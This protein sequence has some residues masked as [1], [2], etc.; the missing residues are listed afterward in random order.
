MRNIIFSA[1]FLL[2]GCSTGSMSNG[3]YYL[4]N[5]R[6]SKLENKY[7]KM[8]LLEERITLLEEKVKN[9]KTVS[10]NKIELVHQVSWLV[11]KNQSRK[12]LIFK[13]VGTEW[14]GPKGEYYKSFPTEKE[15]KL[16]YYE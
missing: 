11:M 3:T 13:M 5:N 1:L 10:N 9:E 7:T 2:A 14:V 16:L 4:L 15:I 12:K 6:I 8:A